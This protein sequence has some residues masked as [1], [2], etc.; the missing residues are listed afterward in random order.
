M[1]VGQ[2]MVR[3]GRPPEGSGEAGRARRTGAVQAGAMA[4]PVRPVA[5]QPAGLE[6]LSPAL[7]GPSDPRVVLPERP[8]VRQCRGPHVVS[9][10]RGHGSGAGSRCPRHVVLLPAL[11]VLHARVARGHRGPAVLLSDVRSRHGVRDPLPLG[12]PND[13]ERVALHGGRPIQGRGD[14][15]PRPRPSRQADA[16]VQRERDRPARHD[17]AVR[18]GRHALRVAVDGHRWAGHPLQRG[19][20]GE[21]PAVRQ[22]DLERRPARRAG[23]RR[24][25]L[26]GSTAR[27]RRARAA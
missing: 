13:H 20:R 12:G 6:H 3:G 5:R 1:A 25:C 19:G 18:S 14:H 11:A 21:R 17:R 26:R 4:A 8:P 15:R 27:R 7:V 24:R 9:G 2:A 23:A 22:Q 10:V 16:Q